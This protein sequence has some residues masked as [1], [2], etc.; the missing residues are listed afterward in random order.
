MI[1]AE[2]A[3]DVV[4]IAT[5]VEAAFGQRAEAV[6]VERIRASDR[7]RPDY[8]LVATLD[9]AV[10]GHVMVSD[11]DLVEGADRRQILS[12]SPLAVDPAL[13]G[14]GSARR[15]CARWRGGSTPMVTR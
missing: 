7:Y 13:H 1:R 8:A 12:L 3:D 11:V 9:G 5:I 6:L 4:S 14:G 2:A 15:W 10:V